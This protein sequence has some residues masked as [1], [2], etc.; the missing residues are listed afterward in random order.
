MVMNMGGMHVDER[1]VAHRAISPFGIK[2]G[3]NP[4]TP[5][6]YDLCLALGG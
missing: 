5:L 4:P 6:G 3:T 2:S 1:Q